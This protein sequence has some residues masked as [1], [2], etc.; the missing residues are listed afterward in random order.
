MSG[1]DRNQEECN[2]IDSEMK[3]KIHEAAADTAPV[4]QVA[5]AAT[6]RAAC[7]LMA[8]VVLE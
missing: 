7:T 4:A 8:F 6:P 1:N 3:T 5:R 2:K